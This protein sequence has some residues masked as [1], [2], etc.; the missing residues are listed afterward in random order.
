MRDDGALGRN[1]LYPGKTLAPSLNTGV[2]AIK[3][4]M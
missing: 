2:T 1:C 3:V 4:K